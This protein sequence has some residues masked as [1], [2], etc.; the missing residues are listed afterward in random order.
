M[1]S[2][3][4]C[5]LSPMNYAGLIP[6]MGYVGSSYERDRM[7]LLF[8]CLFCAWVIE[9]GRLYLRR[10]LHHAMIAKSRQRGA[11]VDTP[12]LIPMHV[13]NPQ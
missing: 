8:T 13:F 6:T 2:I 12:I 11:T 5:I 1:F 3:N 4:Y 7:H 10:D 9:L